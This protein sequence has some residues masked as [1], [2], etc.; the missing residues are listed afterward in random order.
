MTPKTRQ[1]LWDLYHVSTLAGLVGGSFAKLAPQYGLRV[2]GIEDDVNEWTDF[3]VAVAKDILTP[4]E[5][6]GPADD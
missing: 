3:W 2:E 1:V 5:E 6:K 4:A